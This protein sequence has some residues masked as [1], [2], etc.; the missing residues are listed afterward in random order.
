[1]FSQNEQANILNYDKNNLDSKEQELLF[2]KHLQLAIQKSLNMG[3]TFY[4]STEERLSLLMDMRSSKLGKFFLT[5]SKAGAAGLYYMIHNANSIIKD[6]PT[7]DAFCLKKSATVL[8]LRESFATLKRITQNLLHNN[9]NI[10]AVPCG[11]MDILLTLD[12]RGFNNFTLTGIDSDP[13]SLL[14]ACH[15]AQKSNLMHATSLILS[16]IKDLKLTNQF[17]LI[18]SFANTPHIGQNT[19]DAIAFYTSLCQALKPGGVLATTFRTPSPDQKDCPWDMTK[20]DSSD[21]IIDHIYSTEIINGKW[22]KSFTVPQMADIFEQAGFDE[23]E[24]IFDRTRMYP[25]AILKK[26]S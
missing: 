12:Y 5:H 15:F 21:L 25:T 16:D 11:M 20:L 2:E 23:M 24:I 18:T 9:I 3:D 22:L 8:A 14:Q 4:A 7:F 1:M 13:N 17:D 10:A 26:I 19:K 6:L